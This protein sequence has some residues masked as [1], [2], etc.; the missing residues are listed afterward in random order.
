V[1]RALRPRS[2]VLASALV[3]ATTAVGGCGGGTTT[4]ATASTT[5][6]RVLTADRWRPPV[7]PGPPS[8]EKFC[9]LLIAQYQHIQTNTIAANLKVRQ[10]IVGDYVRFTPTVIAAAPPDI[11]PA[12]TT[13]LQDTA[14]ILSLLNAAGLDSAKTPRG[15]IGTI[16]L[17]PRYTSATTQTLAYSQQ[18]CHF[19]IGGAVG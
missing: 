1:I 10:Q 15:S 12:A 18:N 9:A 5:T 17:D 6:A 13:Y 11:A 7:I 14:K 4:K 3:L 8:K 2:L 16:L 19:D